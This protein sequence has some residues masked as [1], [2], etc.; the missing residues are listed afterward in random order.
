MFIN[1]FLLTQN[2]NNNKKEM[3]YLLNIFFNILNK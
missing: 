1:G 3:Q 2:I